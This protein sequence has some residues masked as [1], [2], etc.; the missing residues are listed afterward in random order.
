MYMKRCLLLD[1]SRFPTENR[2]EDPATLARRPS[3]ALAKEER[4]HSHSRRYYRYYPENR[5]AVNLAA[6][7]K[8]L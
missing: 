3:E 1:N 5:H 6:R 2:D 4:V 8:I 7:P